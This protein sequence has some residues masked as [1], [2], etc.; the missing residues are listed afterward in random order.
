MCDL[1]MQGGATS[2]ASCCAACAKAAPQCRAFTFF[3]GT[4]FLKSCATGR[5]A[6]LVGAVSGF[7]RAGS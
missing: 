5:D 2:A 3:G 4:C 1:K 7:L 6:P